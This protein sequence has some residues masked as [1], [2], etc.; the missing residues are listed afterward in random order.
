MWWQHALWFFAGIG[1]AGIVAL[2]GRWVSKAF[3]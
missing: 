2:L 1:V 3:K